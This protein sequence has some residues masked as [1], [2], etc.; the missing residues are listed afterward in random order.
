M[1]QR[2]CTANLAVR[3]TKRFRHFPKQWSLP[4]SRNYS[5]ITLL[6]TRGNTYQKSTATVWC[7]T[8]V[9]TTIPNLS[10]IT[11]VYLKGGQ[12]ALRGWGF[13]EF[14][15]LL[16]FRNPLFQLRGKLSKKLVDNL[17]L[18]AIMPILSESGRILIKKGFQRR[19]NGYKF[20]S[21]FLCNI[22]SRSDWLGVESIGLCLVSGQRGNR[23]NKISSFSKM[24]RFCHFWGH[25]C[26]IG[27]LDWLDCS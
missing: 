10:W 22:P 11:L 18:L 6:R 15:I 16:N 8:V 1:R 12:Q 5:F 9:R 25:Q 26:F 24:R 17:V 2:Y 7:K 14:G 21:T 20:W 3:I 13:A 4:T 27:L 19:G 23:F